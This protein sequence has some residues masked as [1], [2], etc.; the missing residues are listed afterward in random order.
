MH[1]LCGCPLLASAPQKVG[2]GKEAHR[3]GPPSSIT[4]CP[5]LRPLHP[6]NQLRLQLAVGTTSNQRTRVLE[7]DASKSSH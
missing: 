6:F 4:R 3:R 7:R 2:N 5:G 1:T